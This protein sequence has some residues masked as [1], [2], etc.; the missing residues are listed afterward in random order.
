MLV[1]FDL[2]LALRVQ[3]RYGRT[4]FCVLYNLVCSQLYL[5]CLLE[6]I[7]DGGYGELRLQGSVGLPGRFLQEGIAALGSC[8]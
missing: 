1:R 4:P 2:L 7:F 8:P 3:I 5:V 6:V